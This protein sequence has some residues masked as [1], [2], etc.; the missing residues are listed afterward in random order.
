MLV[1][2]IGADIHV[3]I[4]WQF[5]VILSYPIVGTTGAMLALVTLCRLVDN[6]QWASPFTVAWTEPFIQ[7]YTNILKIHQNI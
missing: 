5:Y 2:Y 7:I 1:K 3:T 6:A 4:Y